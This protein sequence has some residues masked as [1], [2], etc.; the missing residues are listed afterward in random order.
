MITQ[1]VAT[2]V[3]DAAITCLITS[4]EPV[5]AATTC[6][7]SGLAQGD[8]YT[9]KVVATNFVGDSVA[10]SASSSMT[11]GDVPSNP[12]SPTAQGMEGSAMVMWET[13]AND[14]GLAI[15]G[16][17]VTTEGGAQVCSTAGAL[18]CTVSGLTNGDSYR[19]R[20]S[21]ANAIGTGAA[22]AWTSF[23]LIGLPLP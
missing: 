10:S 8:T 5:A 4:S 6:T 1:Y 19:F 21:A 16:Y 7:I 14:G 22:S 23:T 12:L 9:F 13:P 20:V 15:S 11:V 2:A 3:E 17:T 18:F